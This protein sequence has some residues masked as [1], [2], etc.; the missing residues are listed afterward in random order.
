MLKCITTNIDI[1]LEVFSK[2]FADPFEGIRCLIYETRPVDS[3][4]DLFARL[5]VRREV[6][7]CEKIRQSL[8]KRCQ[9]YVNVDGGTF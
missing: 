9:T 4:E 3:D 2:G 1:Y 8:T 6:G 7:I 5:S